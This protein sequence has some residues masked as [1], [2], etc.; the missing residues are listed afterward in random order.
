MMLRSHLP[1]SAAI[2]LFTGPA[3]AN[4][5]CRVVGHDWTWFGDHLA[6]SVDYYIF[7]PG[8]RQFEVGTGLRV[9][10]SVWGSTQVASGLVETT[11]YGVG[12]INVRRADDGP[13]FQICVGATKLEVIS[14]CGKVYFGLNDCPTF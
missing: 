8:D 6:L 2:I 4:E 3:Q 1:I 13:D 7:G 14:A 5:M 9:N 12:S 10:G 11:A